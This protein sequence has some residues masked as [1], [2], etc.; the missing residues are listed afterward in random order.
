MY[1]VY[2]GEWRKISGSIKTFY[3]YYINH[4][5]I[6]LNIDEIVNILIKNIYKLILRDI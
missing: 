2:S 3:A 6:P 1:Y 5:N 4:R